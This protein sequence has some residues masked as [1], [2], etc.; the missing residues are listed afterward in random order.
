[1]SSTV[2]PPPLYCLLTRNADTRHADQSV[3]AIDLD[4]DQIFYISFEL[5]LFKRGVG[6]AEAEGSEPGD[7][8]GFDIDY[9]W[10]VFPCDRCYRLSIVKG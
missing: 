9:V 2:L 4:R 3:A 10:H 8:L 1:M 6:E 5:C 7:G